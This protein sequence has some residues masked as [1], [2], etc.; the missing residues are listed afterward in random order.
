MDKQPIVQVKNLVAAY[1]TRTVLKGVNLDIYPGESLAI[2]GRSG[3][4]KSTLLRH[5]IGLAKPVSGQVLIK[6]Q[7]IYAISEDEKVALFKKVGMLFQS[8]ALFNSMTVGDNVAFPLREHTELEESTIQIMMKMKLDL[9]GLSGFDSFKP[10]QLSGG[11]KKRAGLARA[12]AMDPEVLFCDEPSAGLDPVVGAGLDNLILKLKK[13]FRMTIVV[14]THE[15][16]SVF[17]M[18]DRI[19]MMHEGKVLA[20]GSK[21][22]LSGSDNPIIRQFLNR[23]PDEEKI[24]REQYLKTIVGG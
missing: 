17:K 13:A 19:A 24:D 6:G 15:M 7:D 2:L 11:M 9:V 20:V 4:G 5:M 3:C 22:E 10:A 21:E 12:I 18:A 23:E 16:A 1:G 8:A 14:V